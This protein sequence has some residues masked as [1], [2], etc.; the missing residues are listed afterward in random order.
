M[1]IIIIPG[2][3]LQL[4]GTILNANNLLLYSIKYSNQIWIIFKNLFDLY[5]RVLTGTTTMGQSGPG[6]NGNEE[7]TQHSLD[8]PNWSLT[9]WC[10]VVSYS[11]HP[12]F[13]DLTT[14]LC[15]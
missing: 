15:I 4:Q 5:D 11:G 14:L 1:I 8:L 3:E 7:E 2:K 10:S 6:S 12:L 13:R 9:I